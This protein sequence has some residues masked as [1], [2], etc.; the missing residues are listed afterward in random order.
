LLLIIRRL[1]LD[2]GC[3]GKSSWGLSLP[4]QFPAA[5]KDFQATIMV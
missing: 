1:Q 4:L 3:P 5:S 2:L